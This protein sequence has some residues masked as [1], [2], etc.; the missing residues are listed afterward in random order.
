MGGA[1][2]VTRYV[3]A[4]RS[5]ASLAGVCPACAQILDESGCRLGEQFVSPDPGL[6]HGVGRIVEVFCSGAPA[7]PVIACASCGT[8]A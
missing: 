2:R 8:S 5:S 6:T 4:L 1:R 7:G 3:V